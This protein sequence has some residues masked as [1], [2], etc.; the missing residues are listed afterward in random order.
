MTR[1]RT[2]STHTPTIAENVV[3]YSGIEKYIG[4]HL[5]YNVETRRGIFTQVS[6]ES[7]PM[8]MRGGRVRFMPDSDAAEL[9]IIHA[10]RRRK[11]SP[12]SQNV[13]E[14]MGGHLDHLRLHQAAL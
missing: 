1:S 14:W 10:P 12:K 4:K 5:K 2:S 8:H 9:G 11:N 7:G 13:A 3:V 6:G